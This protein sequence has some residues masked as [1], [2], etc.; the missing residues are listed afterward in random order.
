MRLNAIHT[1]V[2]TLITL[3]I[4]PL[5][6]AHDGHAVITHA[7]GL[8]DGFIHP[9]T[10][11]DHLLVTITAGFWAARCGNHGSRDLLF[12]LGAV[13]AG[14][15]VG[16]A[17]VAYPGLGLETVL[18]LFMIA[19][20]VALAIVAPQMFGYALFGSLLVYQ[21]ITHILGI[22]AAASPVLYSTGLLLAAVLLLSLG[23]L[24]RH[25]VL[26]RRP[27]ASTIG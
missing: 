10:G 23:T 20:G 22:P 25:V 13:L 6:H 2:L 16:T 11:L 24:L 8:V 5:A 18:V 19:V 7:A 26:T 15:L 21:G 27:C 14:I 12:L 1:T 3:M 4:A 17:S 9:M